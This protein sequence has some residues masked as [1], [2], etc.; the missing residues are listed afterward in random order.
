MIWV[1]DP[2][3]YNITNHFETQGNICYTREKYDIKRDFYLILGKGEENETEKTKGKTTME[4]PGRH[5]SG[6]GTC[7]LLLYSPACHQYP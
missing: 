7:P 2:N 4:V 5:Y 1:K 6:T 3:R